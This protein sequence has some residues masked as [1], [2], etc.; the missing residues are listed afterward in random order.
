MRYLGIDQSRKTSTFYVSD[1]SGRRI[2]GGTVDNL[3]INF[4]NLV[5]KY[6][7]QD[8]LKVALE[9]GNG[10]FKYARAM[11]DAGAMVWVVDP[12]QNALIRESTKKTDSLDAKQLCEQLRRGMLPPKP[13]YIPTE[14]EEQLRFLVR[15]RARVVKERTMLSNYTVRTA[16]RHG[17]YVK[18]SALSR[19]PAWVLLLTEA[20]GWGSEERLSL[21]QA[22]E[23]F[24]QLE[25]HLGE[26]DAELAARREGTFGKEDKLLET[27]PGFGAATKTAM[28]ARY[29]PIERFS[30]ARQLCRYTGLA[31]SL[32]QSGNAHGR[33]GITKQ[34]DALLRSYL[35]QAAL[36]IIVKANEQEPLYVWYLGV[37][38]RRG[39][40]KA[41]VALARKLVSVAY[42]VLKHGKPYDPNQ[43]SREISKAA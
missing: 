43:V 41:R 39:W 27:I 40:K 32:R 16:D 38:R 25:K 4:A 13:V 26:L 29:G 22:H 10:A 31:P 34:G 24:L 30:N 14:N 9:T 18:K 17:Y 23:R 37:K 19:Q 35:T 7:D 3:A 6:K 42:G 5:S 11:H 1:E 20:Q 15:A 2:A 12:Y 33:G 28:I 36:A 21:K 8:G